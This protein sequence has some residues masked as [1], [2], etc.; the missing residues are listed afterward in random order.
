[1][2]SRHLAIGL[3]VPLLAL[4]GPDLTVSDVSTRRAGDRLL[5]TDTVRN[6]G[7]QR[8]P[9]TRV[10]YRLV[11]R[12]RVVASRTVPS[13]APGQASRATV[14]MKASGARVLACVDAAGRVR[15]SNEAN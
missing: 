12:T 14:R 10:E 2:P 9:R 3:F 4:T 1:M 6:L 8:T 11:G 15:E 7:T 13:L 5:V